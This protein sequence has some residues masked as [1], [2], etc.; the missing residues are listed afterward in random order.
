M[1]YVSS[2]KLLFQYKMKQLVLLYFSFLM[3]IFMLHT[4]EQQ[5]IRI[6][7]IHRFTPT[8][9]IR[10]AFYADTQCKK[11]NLSFSM[12]LSSFQTIIK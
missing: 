1:E 4:A 3:G 5:A 9:A 7:W 12:F 6:K 2:V 10:V 11:H 8:F